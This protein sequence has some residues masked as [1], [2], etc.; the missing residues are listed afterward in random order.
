M[1]IAYLNGSF[2]PLSEARVSVLDRGFLFADGVYEVIPVYGG[3]PFHLQQH[4]LRLERSLSAILLDNPKS[5][6]D[7]SAMI[8]RLLALGKGGDQMLYI[9]VTRGA[10]EGRSHALPA[11]PRPTVLAFCQ[12]LPQMPDSVRTQGVGAITLPD[13]R[14]RHCDVKSIALLGNVL[15][16]N[17]A[18]NVGCNEALLTRDGHLTEGASSNVFVVRDDV[19]STPPNGKEL[20]PGITRDLI[21]KL[22][23]QVGLQTCERPIA[24][25]ELA[26]ADEIWISSSTR[27]LY[28]VTQ[29]DGQAIG[30]QQ[31]GP[32]WQ[33]VYDAFQVFKQQY[34]TQS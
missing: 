5:A 21:L 1:T 2:L 29:L 13:T 3:R 20:L 34:A 11:Q 8:E 22:A 23:Q 27:E 30:N 4:L 18:L 9:Q 14:W 17:Q 25:E 24:T 32:L 26:V 28:A 19:I 12:P 33:K 7:W 16:A 31:P 6:D 15:L 10:S